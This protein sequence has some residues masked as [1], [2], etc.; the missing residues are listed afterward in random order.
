MLCT[1][2]KTNLVA[3]KTV[4]ALTRLETPSSTAVLQAPQTSIWILRSPIL[5]TRFGCHMA[6]L[7]FLRIRLLLRRLTSFS[8]PYRA[9]HT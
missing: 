1:I 7:A 3:K 2:V 4:F 9:H 6:F 8:G 5:K